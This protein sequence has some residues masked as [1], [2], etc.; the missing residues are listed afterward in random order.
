MSRIKIGIPGYK[1]S[2]TFGVGLNHLEFVN[3][4]GDPVILMPHQKEINVD[5]LYLTGGLDLN[6]SLYGEVPGFKTSNQDV[7]K[8][9]FYEHR[10]RNYVG[11]VPIFGVCLGFQMLNVFFGGK[12]QQHTLYHPSSKDRWSKGHE[13]TIRIDQKTT[14][15]IDVNSHH[16]QLVPKEKLASSLI[17]VAEYN[18]TKE[19]VIV[20]GFVHNK[21]PI[22]AVQWHPEE[23]YDEFSDYLIQNLIS[24]LK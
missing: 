24:T 16:H 18:C 15:K 4:Y 9:F 12:L 11:K 10:L 21:L 14:K 3:K 20:E 19:G 7:Y 22:A 8:Q 6:P 1:N 2:E 23:Y 17:S 13:V 5:F